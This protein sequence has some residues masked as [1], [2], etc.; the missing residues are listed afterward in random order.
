MQPYYSSYIHGNTQKNANPG[1]HEQI[2]GSNW[3]GWR[4]QSEPIRTAAEIKVQIVLPP[5]LNVALYH[6]IREKVVALHTLG[7]S[8]AA[9]AKSL[10]INEKTARKALCYKKGENELAI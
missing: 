3:Y 2:N 9:I 8:L 7:M 6:K 5:I 10:K 4:T 1:T